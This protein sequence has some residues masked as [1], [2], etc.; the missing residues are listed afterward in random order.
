MDELLS[1]AR[2]A[3]A[4]GDLDRTLAVLEQRPADLDG[5]D[6]H[7]LLGVVA[8]F[9]DRFADARREWELAFRLYRAAGDDRRAVRSALGIANLHA[10]VFGHEAAAAGWLGRTRRLL[11]RIGPCVEWGYFEL[12]LM[13]CDRPDV[14]EL[15]HSADRALHIADEYHDCDLEALA[16]AEGGLALV[17][18]G[19]Y[20]EG[21][22]RLDEAL[23]SITCGEV[24]NP[25][26]A[27]RA[28][29]AML[30]SCDRVG[31]VRRAQ[32][33]TELAAERFLDHFGGR[34]KILATHCR[35]AYGSVLSSAGRLQEA[36][37]AILA[38]LG[39]GASASE[40]H[41]VSLIARLAELRI[42]QGRLDEAAALLAPY[43]DR[44][45]VG[46]ALARVHL[47]RSEPDL[48]AAV[49]RR[50]LR[51]LVGDAVRGGPLLALLVRAELA[52]GDV[53]SAAVAADELAA[54]A[55][56]TGGAVLHAEAALSQGLVA[57]ARGDHRAA[58][59]DFESVPRCL[60]RD[61]RPLTAAVARLELARALAG[62]GDRSAALIEARA[63]LAAFERLGAWGEVD[64]ASALVRELGGSRR[65]A[66][67][68]RATPTTTGSL[69][70]REVEVLELV[71]QGLTN[72]E[73][74]SRLY[75]SP[76]T[77]EH[78]VGRVLTK[79][80]VRTRAEA[81]GLAA[82]VA[83]TPTTE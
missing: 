32:E 65:A 38:G 47:A 31:D 56:A 11:E 25:A 54:L 70:P 41:R 45:V 68:P 67:R 42:E 33:W 1:E 52:R 74:A 27:G 43:E 83:Y 8:H 72:P 12:A 23:T 30:T 37:A 34:P 20:T 13:A 19:R 39:A 21:F 46:A 3:I 57:V 71:R 77:A 18:Q 48:A 4:V 10:H 62:C 5:P 73:I 51:Q 64:R 6:V 59:L 28:F 22:G 2:G 44:L 55:L 9:D 80:G 40:S 82:T 53:A 17:S 16:L 49:A 15:E 58:V 60:A 7:Q 66:V 79:L 75:I 29:C 78:H 81:A 63:A 35:L 50:G 24:M 61:E 76:K 14:V 69:T 26:I 36:E